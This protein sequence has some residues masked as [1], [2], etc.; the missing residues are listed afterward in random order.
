MVSRGDHLAFTQDYLFNSPS[1]AAGA[2][3]GRSAN[4]RIDWTDNSGRTLKEFEEEKMGLPSG[5]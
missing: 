5:G 2:I 1:T 4:G 3:Q